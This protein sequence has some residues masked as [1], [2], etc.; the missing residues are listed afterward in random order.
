MDYINLLYCKNDL[1]Q[2]GLFW[3]LK[4]VFCKPFLRFTVLK[5][6]F[7]CCM[8]STGRGCKRGPMGGWWDDEMMFVSSLYKELVSRVMKSKWS[9]RLE[10]HNP[11]ASAVLT[12]NE[13]LIPSTIDS[14]GTGLMTSVLSF[15]PSIHP[16]IYLSIQPSIYPSIIFI[17]PLSI[18]SIYTSSYLSI[19]LLW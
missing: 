3:K 12:I 17:H 4:M 8:Y 18:I 11:W 16:S 13:I 14:K 9:F 1:L 6:F 7:W 10:L 2:R 19:H 5:I 15:E